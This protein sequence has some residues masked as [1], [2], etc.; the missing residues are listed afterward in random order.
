MK[1]KEYLNL[2]TESSSKAG[3][4]SISALNGAISCSLVLKAYNLVKTRLDKDIEDK[5]RTNFYKEIL[6]EREF[7]EEMIL[8]DGESFQSVLDAIKLPK[9]NDDEKKYRDEELQ[10]AYKFALETPLNVMLHLVNLFEY[11]RELKKHTDSIIKTELDI[12]MY[13]L[14]SGI[15]S[16]KVLIQIN[17]KHLDDHKYVNNIIS[18]VNVLEE[19]VDK[20]SHLLD[21][22]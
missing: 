11:V 6:T 3:G 2:L 14:I 13:E 19:Q 4:G 20:I 15:K 9:G 1:L 8:K 16:S 7:F 22:K 12:A 21:K 5:L 17:S 18:K 10:K